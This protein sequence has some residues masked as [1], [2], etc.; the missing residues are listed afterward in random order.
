VQ[1]VSKLGLGAFCE[2]V[3]C[4]VVVDSVRVFVHVLVVI[5]AC[6]IAH[7][8]SFLARRAP[9]VFVFAIHTL[10]LEYLKVQRH[11]EKEGISRGCWMRREA[12]G[13]YRCRRGQPEPAPGALTGAVY[14]AAMALAV[15]AA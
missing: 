9:R 8:R 3:V 15:Y 1:H 4:I 2:L 14:R 11:Q 5:I 7:W 10:A 6:V 12:E 13:S